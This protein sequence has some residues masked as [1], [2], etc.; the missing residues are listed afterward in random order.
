MANGH[1][2]EIQP[3]GHPKVYQRIPRP[4]WIRLPHPTISQFSKAEFFGYLLACIVQ[5]I[6]N[7]FSKLCPNW[8]LRWFCWC[9][10]S[11]ETLENAEK[12]VLS[13]LKHSHD[14]EYTNIG[15]C[16]EKVDSF[17][18]TVSLNKNSNKTPLVLL[19]G[20]ACGSGVWVMNLDSLSSSRPVYAIDLLGFGLSSRP[21]FSSDA[22]EAEMQFF[23]SLEKWR[24]SVGLEKFILL[25]HS[26]GGYIAASYALHYPERV[27]LL[28][29]VDP[30][31]LPEKPIS[32]LHRYDLDSW[33]KLLDSFLQGFNFLASVRAAGPIGPSLVRHFRSDLLKKYGRFMS[34]PECILQYIYHCNVQNPSGEIAFKA[35]TDKSGWAK[36]PMMY[37]LNNLDWK[38]P[39]TF[40]YGSRSWI[41]RQPGLQIKYSRLNSFVDVQVIEGAG[42]HVYADKPQ[43]FNSMMNRICD[44]LESELFRSRNY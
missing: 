12:D 34:N 39:I 5:F 17:I 2:R 22:L 26:M 24:E 21:P 43:E 29:L 27:A 6:P 13:N 40:V 25:G 23:I 4:R 31:G 38:I 7:T 30:W 18:R 37:R 11:K 9:P 32:Y 41:N 1:I 8:I 36:Y 10:T 28:I 3:E 16:C 14:I 19:H 44:N 42:H 15:K 35:M 20:F 33:V